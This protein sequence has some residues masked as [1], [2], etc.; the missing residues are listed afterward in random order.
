MSIYA[1]DDPGKLGHAWLTSNEI[2]DLVQ[3]AAAVYRPY[4]GT[5]PGEAPPVT[6]DMSSLK[7]YI[8]ITAVK[9]TDSNPILSEWFKLGSGG[10][11]YFERPNDNWSSLAV[12]GGALYLDPSSNEVTLV[13]RGTDDL[14][15]DAT[16]YKDMTKHYAVFEPLLKHLYSYIEENGITKVKVAGHSLGGAMVEYF[17]EQHKNIDANDT[18]DY[19]DEYTK[20]KLPKGVTYAAVAVAS[21]QAQLSKNDT[22]LLNIGHDDDKIFRILGHALPGLIFPLHDATITNNL[23]YSLPSGFDLFAPHDSTYGY[24]HSVRT[25]LLSSNYS[26]TS[27]DSNVVIDLEIDKLWEDFSYDF[28]TPALILGKGAYPVMDNKVIA[29]GGIYQSFDDYLIGTIYNDTLEGFAGNDILYGDPAHP[30]ERGRDTMSGGAGTDTFLGRTRDL[31]G[32]TITDLEIGDKIGVIG[33]TVNLDSLSINNERTIITFDTNIIAS[34]PWDPVTIQAKIPEGARLKLKNKFTED[35]TFDESRLV[36]GVDGSMGSIIEVVPSDLNNGQDISFVIDTTSSMSDDIYKVK[37]SAIDIINSVFD[38]DRDL[39]NSRISVVGYN[40]PES[41]SG[42]GYKSK[43]ILSFTDHE[44]PDDRKN[45]ALAAINAIDVFGGGDYPEYTYEGLLHALDGRAGNWRDDALAR[46]IILFGDASAKD[47]E[48]KPKVIELANNLNATYSSS[49]FMAPR[50]KSTIYNIDDLSG[51]SAK[52]SVQIFTIQIGSDDDT[53]AD[54]FQEISSETGGS[55][56]NAADAN[57]IVQALLEVIKL[58]IYQISSSA[59]SLEE[60]NSGISTLDI[61]IERDNASKEAKVELGLSGAADDDDRS[62][63]STLVSFLAGEATKTIQ[64]AIQG[65]TV[66]EDDE[67]VIISIVDITEDASIDIG[68]TTVTIIN[69]DKND[70]DLP[71]IDNTITGDDGKN[72]LKGTKSNDLILGYDGRDRLIG[73]K[74]DDIL[75]GGWGRDKLAGGQGDDFLDGGWDSDKLTGGKGDDVIDGGY[76]REDQIADIVKGGPGSDTFVIKDTYWTKVKDFNLE[77]DLLDLNGLTQG[78]EWDYR[79]EDDTTYI[80]GNDGDEVAQ[81]SGYKNLD[82][83][84]LV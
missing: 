20:L 57:E 52:S 23:C 9:T 2:V 80:W 65:D 14:L 34:I 55:L 51:R 67:N 82:L 77:Q 31:D 66:K 45:A 62:L 8:N 32:D 6:W 3:L 4:V 42:Y 48:T 12:A 5:F 75:R 7:D 17:M 39:L 15:S 18:A 33:S 60:G 73:K 84:N 28:E 37:E 54:E 59:S 24:V 11:F 38:E 58:P 19:I 70:G 21:P 40:D 49:K 56:F 27:R 50:I 1:N 29:P 30:T 46:K 43:T 36:R 81:F 83:A 72:K 79:E 64:L 78:L 16:D 25:L 41:S 13:F 68:Q 22:R 69:D 44:N 47:P 76:W 35:L 10:Q 74:G 63:N 26:S 53:V 71:S 61:T